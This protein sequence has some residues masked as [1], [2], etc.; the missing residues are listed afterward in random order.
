[1]ILKVIRTVVL[2]G[3]RSKGNIS[4]ILKAKEKC[5]ETQ[6]GDHHHAVEE[7]Q[8]ERLNLLPVDLGGLFGDAFGNECLCILHGL[9]VCEA[10]LDLSFYFSDHVE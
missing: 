9:L 4:Q 3:H 7:L 10:Q 1:M 5:D 6:P 2:L 8:H